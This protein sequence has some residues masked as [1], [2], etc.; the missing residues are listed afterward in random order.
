MQYQT[1]IISALVG[2]TFSF[3]LSAEENQT[4]RAD[5]VTVTATREAQ[6]VS[7]TPATVGVISDKT[8]DEVKPGHPSEI[9]ERVP[10]VHVNV[11]G[12]EGHM[13]AIRLPITTKALYL[14][15]EDGIPTRSTGFFNHNALY[16]VNLPQSGG[17]EILKGPGSALYGS[18]AIGAVINVQTRP[19]P[20]EFEASADLEVGGYGW[21]RLL[22][23]VGN[24]WGDDGIRADLNLTSTDGWRDHTAY[25]RQSETFRWVSIFK[26]GSTLKTIVT[27]SNIDQ[28][29][30]GSS[31]LLKDDYEN[32]PT[33]NYTPISYR[34][35]DALRV[36]TAWEKET[37][38][39]LWS[40]TPYVRS[41]SMDI[42]P[43]WS[44]S[45]DPVKYKTQNDSLGALIKY[46][47]DFAPLRTRLIVG[48]DIDY[49]PG[50]RD[51][52][53]LGTTRVGNIYTDYTVVGTIY[54]Y[55][56]TYTGVSPYLH[57]ELS[58]TEALRLTLGLRYDNL[59]YDYTNNLGTLTTGNHRRPESTTVSFSRLSPKLGATYTFNKSFNGFASYSQ[60]FRA[61]SESQL[62]RQGRAENTVDLKPVIAD[63]LELGIRS[64][65]KSS[66]YEVSVYSMTL[67]DDI[68]TF[69]E[70]DGTRVT[71]NAGK[72]LHQ[73]IELGLGTKFWSGFN[74][75]IA[76]SYA[77]HTYEEW[78]PSTTVDYSGNE[79]ENAP[80]LIANTRLGYRFAVLNNGKLE[81]EWVKLGDYWMDQV[82]TYK[83]DGHDIFNLRFNYPVIP[84]LEL[85]AR[86]MNLADTRYAT[87]AKYSPAA[88]GNPEKFEYAPG[89]PR[90][91]YAG[92]KY[93]F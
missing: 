43:N 9:M 65:Y 80:R 37:S 90:T 28:E 22:G 6:R 31:R 2:I 1:I 33:L 69:R 40:V 73:G 51:E 35:V 48:A 10:G 38:S 50:S 86:L 8:I 52:Q 63:S 34:N 92:L 5:T 68:L 39:S 82:N 26:N 41:N 46:R 78:R 71:Q 75:D 70:A 72:T 66:H 7:E 91:F 18:D 24:T 4:A 32:N 42:L 25:D 17:V 58:P 3:S 59:Q 76:A 23:T 19:A 64:Q 60:G 15:L 54:D 79:M 81:L 85:Y 55:D 84:S 16:E 49:S 11:T 74:F 61:P 13:T 30:A 27:G 87:S 14:Y 29:T 88:F 57:G 53:E 67:N 20:L 12:G 21:K 93:S 83:Y 44:L 89:M 47:K 45:Y 77:K 56:V 36:S 62:F